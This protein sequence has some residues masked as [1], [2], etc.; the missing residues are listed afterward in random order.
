MM[1]FA[2]KMINFP[3]R[4]NI[5]CCMPGTTYDAVDLEKVSKM[6]NCVLKTRNCVSQKR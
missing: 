6:M 2:S 3:R 5:N 4:F 1:N